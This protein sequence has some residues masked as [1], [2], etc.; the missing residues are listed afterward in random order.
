MVW[1]TEQTAV[2]LLSF[3]WVTGP[4]SYPTVSRGSLSLVVAWTELESQMIQIHVRGWK[5]DRL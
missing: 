4:A 2:C 5:R 3:R 1:K